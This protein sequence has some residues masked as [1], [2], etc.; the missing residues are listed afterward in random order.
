MEDKDTGIFGGVGTGWSFGSK[1]SNNVAADP[2]HHQN[3]ILNGSSVHFFSCTCA[4]RKW[5]NSRCKKAGPCH[6]TKASGSMDMFSVPSEITSVMNMMINPWILVSLNIDTQTHPVFAEHAWN[7]FAAF[8]PTDSGC[9]DR[10]PAM[11]LPS[12]MMD[13]KTGAMQ[14]LRLTTLMTSLQAVVLRKISSL[15]GKKTRKLLKMKMD[16][17]LNMDHCLVSIVFLI[18]FIY[19]L[20]FLP[21][22]MD[23]MITEFECNL[24]RSVETA[25]QSIIRRPMVQSKMLKHMLYSVHMKVGFHQP[26]EK[27]NWI[28]P[29][30]TWGGRRKLASKSMLWL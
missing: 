18:L 2:M 7:L 11:Q 23:A 20:W 6:I 14:S 9:Q 25:K 16:H 1:Q 29:T 28:W 8:G 24:F 3:D 19:V 12:P 4:V 22:N 17:Q 15:D 13:L 5:I 10:L 30:S 26:L 27:F 21:L